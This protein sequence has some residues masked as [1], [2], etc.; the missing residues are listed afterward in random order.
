[1]PPPRYEKWT[2]DDETKFKKMEDKKV[3]LCDTALGR[4]QQRKRK[5]M[6]ESFKSATKEEQEDMLKKLKAIL[7]EKYHR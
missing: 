4:F 1:M 3:E 7:D 5:E 2:E 6:E